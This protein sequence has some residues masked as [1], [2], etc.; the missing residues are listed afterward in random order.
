V[1]VIAPS[2]A[3]IAQFQFRVLNGDN[4][5]Q[6][7]IDDTLAVDLP[8]NSDI[9]IA[10]TSGQA[11]TP[12]IASGAVSD[13]T[14]LFNASP[15]TV[16]W[17]STETLAQLDVTTDD[18]GAVIVQVTATAKIEGNTSSLGDVFSGEAKLIVED[19]FVNDDA[20]S[21]WN[22]LGTIYM[23]ATAVDGP[24]DR[25]RAT[26]TGAYV[27]DNPGSTETRYRVR[28]DGSLINEWKVDINNSYVEDLQMVVTELKK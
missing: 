22:E 14:T 28:F 19:Q 1:V 8:R 26:F 7:L 20:V 9:D 13:V 10:Q 16:D 21:G 18:L 24:A 25:L 23:R 12:N 5:S 3:A 6:A 2:Q 27:D 17:Q 4:T 15:Q 11:D